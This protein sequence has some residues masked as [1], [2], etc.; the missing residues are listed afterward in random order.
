MFLHSQS[1]L[2]PGLKPEHLLTYAEYTEYKDKFAEESSRK[3]EEFTQE[4][5][6]NFTKQKWLDLFCHIFKVLVQQRI[7]NPSPTPAA[8]QDA[9]EFITKDKEQFDEYVQMNIYRFSKFFLGDAKLLLWLE[10]HLNRQRNILWPN[11]NFMGTQHLKDFSDIDD[12]QVLE[13]HFYC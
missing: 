1:I 5:F 6:Y 12:R 7:V 8:E 13:I 3:K 4:T 2:V 11:E 10:Y 9:G